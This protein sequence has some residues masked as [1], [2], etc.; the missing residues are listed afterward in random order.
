MTTFKEFI[1]QFNL[2]F[3]IKEQD[4]APVAGSLP[5]VPEDPSKN[6]TN[7]HHFSVLKR[8]LGIKDS[9]FKSALES[10][11]MTVYNVPRYRHWGFWVI[12][13]CTAIITQRDDGKYDIEYQLKTKSLMEP[14]NFI[15][16]YKNGDN[17][18]VYQGNIENKTE[19]ATS[20]ELQDIVAS[21][22]QSVSKAPSM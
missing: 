16:P 12:G 18:I 5:E 19:V 1:N 4:S 6:L 15:L 21:P 11:P 3:S 22:V 17:P 14:N 8:E 13:P 7:K 20:E 9:S 10:D 2:N